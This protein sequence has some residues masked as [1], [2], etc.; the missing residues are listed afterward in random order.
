VALSTHWHLEV[1][2]Q[3]KSNRALQVKELAVPPLF[4]LALNDTVT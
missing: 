4:V 3:L 2:A 1:S